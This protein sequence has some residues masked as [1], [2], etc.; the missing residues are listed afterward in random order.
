VSRLRRF[1]LWRAGAPVALLCAGLLFATSASNARGTDLR[2]S[3]NTT[4]AGLV[5]EQSRRSATLTRQHAALS[6]DIDKLRAQQG[7]FPP[8]LA[9]QLE[10]L[11]VAVGT[12][13]VTGP[14]LTVTLKDAPPEVVKDNPDVDADW[15]VIHQQDI[16]AVVN[17]LWAGGADAISIQD[18]RVIS[19]TG[20]K[21]VGN[22]VVLH[23]VP[24]LP[25]YRI[26][27]IGDRRKLQQSLDDSKYIENLQDYVVKFQLGYEVKTES[28]I[29]M[30]AYEGTLDLQSATVPGFAKTPTVSPSTSGR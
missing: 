22:S 7:S 27:A 29:A 16:Q 9:K 8:K 26:T 4:L 21:C 18:H 14:G 28:N 3:R 1:S 6:G 2:P 17:A 5:E 19:T 24:Y 15:L 11:S 20:I 13:P 30:P 23:G 10:D 25:P 12:T